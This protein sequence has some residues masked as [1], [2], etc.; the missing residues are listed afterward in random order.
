FDGGH[1]G[2]VASRMHGGDGL[3]ELVQRHMSLTAVR[4]HLVRFVQVFVDKRG[5]REF[6]SSLRG[7]RFVVTYR[8]R[9][10]DERQDYQHQAQKTLRM[11]ENNLPFL[12]INCL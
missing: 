11:D 7:Q 8:T 3:F 5:T 12:V 10:T 6:E 1:L 9:A 2:R 4:E